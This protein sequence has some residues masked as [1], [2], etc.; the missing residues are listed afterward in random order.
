MRLKNQ[1]V[2]SLKQQ[3]EN[4]ETSHGSFLNYFIVVYQNTKIFYESLKDNGNE[5]L[6]FIL[7]LFFVLSENLT[8]QS[9]SGYIPVCNS[10]RRFESVSTPDDL[11]VACSTRT[12]SL[13]S[14]EPDQEYT[15]YSIKFACFKQSSDT[16]I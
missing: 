5:K 16:L 15:V 12:D 3:T 11:V 8:A 14:I 10:K 2:S 9:G 6:I 13:I 1:I 4:Q 7:L